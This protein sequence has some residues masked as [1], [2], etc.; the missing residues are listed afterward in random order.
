MKSQATIILE[1]RTR[2]LKEAGQTLD[3]LLDA[4]GEH[5]N[6]RVDRVELSGPPEHVPVTIPAPLARPV[7]DAPAPRRPEPSLHA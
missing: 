2:S 4:L 3:E 5:Q 1:L 6:V 7:T